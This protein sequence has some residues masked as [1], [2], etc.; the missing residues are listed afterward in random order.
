MSDK[1]WEVIIVGSGP[2]GYTSAIYTSRAKLSTLLIA[3]AVPGGQLMLTTEVENY[4]GFSQGILG[5]E[6]MNEMNLQ[7]KRFGAEILTEDVSKI[8]ISE[9]IKKVWVGETEY[10]AKTIILTVGAKARMLDVGEDKLIGR[11]VSTCAT[12]DAAFFRDKVTFVVGGGDVAMEDALAL[13]KYAKTV[14]LIHRRDSFKAS[15]IMQERVL[16]EKKLPVLW[17]SEVSAVKGD[18]KLS[19]I[20]VKN[21]K[22]GEEQELPAD[23]LFMAIGHMPASDFCQGA[24]E[25]DDHGYI[26]TRLVK[27]GVNARQEML[28][29]FPTMTNIEGVFAAGD[30]VDFRYKQVATSSGMGCMAALDVEKYLTGQTASW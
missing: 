15:K 28:E 25:I 22:T 6:L 21:L 2:A 30:V 27:D 8:D 12:C 20:V 18:G 10:Q 16:L 7:A 29:G 9:K 24:I 11:G 13:T 23:G 14:T 3:G 17:N 4:P 19:A 26:V 5:P 1:V